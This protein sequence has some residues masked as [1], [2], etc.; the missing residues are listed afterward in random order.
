M[1]LGVLA[2]SFLRTGTLDCEAAAGFFLT[3][4]VSLCVC[5]CRLRPDGPMFSHRCRLTGPERVAPG[6][7][8][9]RPLHTPLVGSGDRLNFPPAGHECTLQPLAKKTWRQKWGQIPD[10]KRRQKAAPSQ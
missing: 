2:A 5:C 4:P 9:V 6:A 10:E 7:D 1:I 8:G 3:A